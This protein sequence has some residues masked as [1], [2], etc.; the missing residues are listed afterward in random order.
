[1]ARKQAMNSKSVRK[2]SRSQPTSLSK[3]V[4]RA[5]D[6]T[7]AEVANMPAGALIDNVTQASESTPP[8]TLLQTKLTVGAVG[9]PYEQEADRV[10]RQVVNQ[11]HSSKPPNTLTDAPVQRQIQIDHHSAA[12][13]Q[14]DVGLEGGAV[15]GDIESTINSAK[16]SGQALSAKTQ[17]SMGGAMGADFSSVKVHT[18]STSDQLNRSMQSRAFTTGSHIFFKKG[19]YSPGNRTGQELLAHELTHTVQQGASPQVQQQALPQQTSEPNRTGMPLQLK[20]GVES[21]SGM[22]MSDVKVHYNSPEPTKIGALAYTRGTDI[23]LAPKQEQHLAH[24]AWHVVQQKQGRVPVTTQFKKLAGNDSPALEREADVM[25][26]K[27]AAFK[28]AQPVG[29]VQQQGLM[30]RQVVQARLPVLDATAFTA[31][32]EVVR[33]LLLHTAKNMDDGEVGSLFEAVYEGSEVDITTSTSDEKR[34]ELIRTLNAGDSATLKNAYDFI[35]ANL[36]EDKVYEVDSEDQDFGALSLTHQ[37]DI[38]KELAGISS[39]L[40]RIIGNTDVQQQIFGP[41]FDQGTIDSVYKGIKGVV[42][43]AVNGGVVPICVTGNKDH[44]NWVGAGALAG[45]GTGVTVGDPAF[46][47]IIAGKQAGISTL[48]HEFSHFAASTKDIAYS[49]S[50]LAKLTTEE[51]MNNAE[52]YAQAFEEAAYGSDTSRHYDPMKVVD[53][54]QDEDSQRDRAS[55]NVKAHLKF[56]YK[57]VIRLWNGVD[58]VYLTAI[59]KNKDMTKTVML[60]AVGGDVSIETAIHDVL[61]PHDIPVT[62]ENMP[63]I[64]ALI[65]D[66]ARAIQPGKFKKKKIQEILMARGVSRDDLT[67]KPKQGSEGIYSLTAVALQH[68]LNMNLETAQKFVKGS[69]KYGLE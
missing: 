59:T 49:K 21:L 26:A 8:T 20:A 28:G 29:M 68:S 35:V 6:S 61:V 7:H 2:S 18:D 11:L 9:D 53:V 24:E 16:S 34:Q 1:M 36:G 30:Q 50:T 51:R 63:M 48:V 52:T 67:K 10:A 39:F 15:S 43:K 55:K 56:I 12:T 40:G 45:D 5:A 13:V 37:G 14:A 57:N 44:M 25:G 60:Q 19:E 33:D 38:L 69:I 17:T 42:N 64:L 62:A 23:H 41:E 54:E 31:Q 65:E 32:T 66:R 22:S 58:N 47:K 4:M 3:P 27:A 46:Q